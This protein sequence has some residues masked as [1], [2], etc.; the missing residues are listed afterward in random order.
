MKID[1]ELVVV[2]QSFN[3]SKKIVWKAITEIDQM[4]KWF[5]ENIPEKRP[6]VNSLTNIIDMLRLAGL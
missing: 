5:F 2:E 1:D 6:S 3:A 4:T